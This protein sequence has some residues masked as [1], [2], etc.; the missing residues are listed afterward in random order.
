M[1]GMGCEL[2]RFVSSFSV[3][4]WDKVN[5]WRIIY[6]WSEIEILS[7]VQTFI[8]LLCRYSEI[9]IDFW[10]TCFFF[11]CKRY[12]LT[13]ATDIANENAKAKNK[14]IEAMTTLYVIIR[15][16]IKIIGF[17]FYNKKKCY[18]YISLEIN[19]RTI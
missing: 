10:D 7:F 3:K 2:E 17:D 8:D 13:S 12:I 11:S 4:K 14:G 5:L 1:T 9:F 6:S 15:K 19:Y 18:K 16:M